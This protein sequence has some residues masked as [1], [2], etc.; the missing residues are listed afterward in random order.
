MDKQDLTGLK[1]FKELTD[2]CA[3]RF[4]DVHFMEYKTPQGVAH[5]TYAELRAAADGLSTFLTENGL[6]GSHI[7]LVGKAGF[8]WAAAFLGIVNAGS[9]AVPLAPAETDDMNEQLVRFADCEALLFDAAHRALYE[10]IKEKAPA[11]RMF[12]TFDDADAPEDI[13]R[14]NDILEQGAPVFPDRLQGDELCA[15]MFTSGTTGFP[16]GVMLTHRN[17]LATAVFVH[18]A[19]D[20]PR[21]LGVL[22]YHHAFGLTG[23]IT[24]IMV[25]GRTLCLNDDIRNLFDDFRLYRPNGMLAVP[26]MIRYMMNAAFAYA[27]QNADR[28]SEREAVAEF[29]G[30]DFNTISSGAA[31]LDRELNER[32]NATGV[33]VY[34]GYGM[35]E[36]A[37]IVSNNVGRFNKCGSVGRPIPC[38]QVRFDDGEILLK[39]RNVTQ[40]YYKN[41]EATAEAF[42]PDGWLRTGDMGYLDEDGYLYITGRKKN[43]ILLDNGENVSAEYLEE[44]LTA[45]PAVRECVC[46]GDNGAICAEIYP[47]PSAAGGDPAQ[48]VAQA[49]ERVNASLAVFQQIRKTILRDRPFPRTASQKIIRQGSAAAHKAE[50]SLPENDAEQTVYDNVRELLRSDTFGMDDDFFAVGGSSLNAA[51][52]AVRLNLSPQDIYHTPV[53][54]ALAQK[55]RRTETDAPGSMEDLNA[56][57][58][59]TR[60]EEP[61]PPF[62]TVL[63][64]G[65]TGFLGAHIL[66]ELLSAGKTVYCLVRDEQKLQNTLTYYFGVSSFD[67]AIPVTGDIE[68]PLLGLAQKDYDTLAE[69]VDCVFHTAAN[70]RHAGDYAALA[71]TNVTG[72]KNVIAFAKAAGAALQHTS[73]VSIHG[74]GTT[75]QRYENAPF[76]EN[77]LDIGQRYADN[78]YIHSKF[79]AEQAVLSARREGLRAN[80]FRIGNLTWRSSDGKFQPNAGDNGFLRRLHAILKLGMYNENMDKFPMD[81]TPVDECARA[82]VLLALRGGIDRVYHLY[83]PHCLTV[84][85]LFRSLSLP[86]RYVSTAE[87]V[88]VMEANRDDPDIAVYLFYL[89]ISGR[90]SEVDVSC[91]KT[92]TALRE[93]GFSWS[94]PDR[95]YLTLSPDGSAGGC[96]SFTPVRLRP[97][98]EDNTLSETARLTLGLLKTAVRKQPKLLEGPGCVTLLAREAASLGAKR[99]LVITVPFP[100]PGVKEMTEALPGAATFTDISA[101]PT[102][103]DIDRALAL[104]QEK[105]CDS[106]IGIG[107]G[108]VLDT[109]KITALRAANPGC[110]A[111]DIGRLDSGCAHCVPLLLAPST[112]GTGSE[113]TLFAVAVEPEKNKKRAF[114]CDRFLPDVVALDP[115]LTSSVPPAVTAQTGIDALAHAVESRLSLFAPSFPEDTVETPEAVRLIF[116]HLERA[117]KQPDDLEA[118]AAMQR[119]AYLAGRSFGRIGTGYIHAIA[120]RLGEF[121]HVP[122]GLAVASVFTPVLY[123][124]APY[125]EEPLARLARESGTGASWQDFLKAVD[126]LIARVG[127]SKDAVPFRPADAF[128]I[129]RRAQEEAKLVGCPKRFSDASL[130]RL[131]ES[132]FDAS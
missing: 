91:E 28:L 23:N 123:A 4:A 122:H 12:L 84:P 15:V 72:T 70:V 90:S 53:L 124:G 5:K 56:L 104:Y 16:K 51:E 6:A 92:E 34:N 29:F 30:G 128:E 94:R 13:W 50:R 112:A 66:K 36:C 21:M 78:V 42:T 120:H 114:T 25:N 2:Y 113:A 58:R 55:L 63:L 85:A 86:Y 48:A 89:L 106:V 40:G 57:L 79:R 8:P 129:A 64:T 76:D 77:T 108:S 24:K 17:L 19:Y 18:D 119:A 107:G 103:E 38:M 14:V 98:A 22:P 27:E 65:A 10:R 99:P 11:V 81:L 35:T 115:V 47:E 131:I 101:E 82:F 121:Y 71:R 116:A 109:A 96:L 117:V 83:D 43:L 33:G 62:S 1:S 52:L 61:A 67:G 60:S 75:T 126:G 87:T 9:V 100:L 20:T 3:S 132:I 74:A 102:T 49:V 88:G 44:K 95:G 105:K 41:P 45:E 46:F 110:G 69:R 59:E 125:V 93:L 97:M 31:P 130:Q 26:Q 68:A 111:G 39:G 127:I 73:T 37:P 80:I 7:A 118:R 32:Y 54:R